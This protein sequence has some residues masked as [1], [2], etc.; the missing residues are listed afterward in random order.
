MKKILV[1]DDDPLVRDTILRILERKGY[2][3]LVAADGIRGLRLFHAEQP[4]LVI[5]DIIMPEKEHC[6][7]GFYGRLGSLEG[8][9]SLRVGRAQRRG[10]GGRGCMLAEAERAKEAEF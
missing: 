8:E 3:V 10:S 9:A 1:I 7:P 5:T 4:D 2:S 6:C